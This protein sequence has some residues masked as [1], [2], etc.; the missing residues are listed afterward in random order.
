MT[1]KQLVIDY[2][3]DQIKEGNLKP[4]KRILSEEDLSLKLGVSRNTLRL[5]FNILEQEGLIERRHGSGT[6]IKKKNH[7]YDKR[8]KNSG[9]ADGR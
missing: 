3:K 5:A 6:Y 4:G 8:R 1:K 2:I 9:S 7:G